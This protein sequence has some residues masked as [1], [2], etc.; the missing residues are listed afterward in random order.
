MTQ[1]F[2]VLSKKHLYYFVVNVFK[3]T[4]LLEVTFFKIKLSGNFEIWW[5][6]FLYNEATPCRTGGKNRF[7]GAYSFSI[8]ERYFHKISTSNEV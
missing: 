3:L 5:Q 1:A 8:L 6:R 7:F 4:I 2:I